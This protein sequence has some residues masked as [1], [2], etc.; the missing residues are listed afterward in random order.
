MTHSTHGDRPSHSKTNRDLSI[1]K[2][3]LVLY[4]TRPNLQKTLQRSDLSLEKL[5]QEG[6]SLSIPP[7]LLLK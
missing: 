4:R 1:W 2:K 6:R 3:A 7:W 5:T